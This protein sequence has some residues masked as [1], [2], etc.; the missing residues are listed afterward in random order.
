M[1]YK[2]IKKDFSYYR[3]FL[4][5]DKFFFH[6]ITKQYIMFYNWLEYNFYEYNLLICQYWMLYFQEFCL[7]SLRKSAIKVF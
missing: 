3:N 2:I 4:F 7:F 1:R 6:S 5:K